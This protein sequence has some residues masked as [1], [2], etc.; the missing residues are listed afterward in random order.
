MGAAQAAEKGTAPVRISNRAGSSPF[1]LLCDHAS[2][3]I[4]AAYGTLGL[5]LAER[6]S[7]IAWDPGA[8]PVS[9][10]IA[11]ALDAPLVESCISRLVIDCNRPLDAPDLVTEV[12]ER[13]I[14]PGNHGL[15]LEARERR[16]AVAHAPYHAAIEQLIE[17][18]L[19]AGL[20]CCLVAIHS[21]TPMYKG[22]PR[23]WHVGVIHDDDM[24][25]AG[26]ML[27]A[28]AAEAGVTV[29]DNQPYSPAD[30]VYYTVERHARWGGLPCAM[31]EIRNDEI[32][33]AAGQR[34]WAARLATILAGIA[35]EAEFTE[36]EAGKA[37]ADEC[38]VRLQPMG[39]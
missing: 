39:R 32:A 1:L 36:Q 16:V 37:N 26:P 5:T 25:L 4:P 9:Q 17:E 33:S 23:R 35:V 29:G 7:H 8:L 6:F 3:F 28:L 15:S 2:N 10:R 24:R 31:V 19:A 18:R 30:R 21:F 34:R 13:T 11:A 20:G 12:S 22:V 27:A 14:V 38:G